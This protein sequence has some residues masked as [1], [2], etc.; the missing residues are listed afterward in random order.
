M[1]T[2]TLF[3]NVVR[4]PVERRARPTMSLLREIRPDVRKI[5]ALVE[6]FGMEPPPIDLRERADA[7][8]A[9]YIVNHLTGHGRSLDGL[10]Q[11]V[12]HTAVAACRIAQDAALTAADAARTVERAQAAGQTWLDPLVERVESLMQ[13]YTELALQAH[14]RAEEAE[15]VGRAVALARRGV[16]WT[17]LDHHAETDG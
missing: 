13:S 9:E 1:R 10:V 5:S 6:A 12:V 17:P 2:E 14:A 7:E 15:G 16:P 4:F 11:P 3:G 8:T